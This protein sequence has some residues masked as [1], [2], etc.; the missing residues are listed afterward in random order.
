MVTV[1]IDHPDIEKYIDWKVV[2]E[3]KV[4]ALVAGSKLANQHMTAV[5]Q[6]CNADDAPDGEDRFDPRENRALKRA[7]VAARKAMIPE[8]YVQRVIQFA[9][10]GYKTGVQKGRMQ[11]FFHGTGH[12][13]GLQIHE[14]PSIGKR[15]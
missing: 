6:A 4:A 1:D 15:P 3:Q 7:I 10:Q 12:G 2:E 5:M 14:A 9:R 11:G 13:V 8:N